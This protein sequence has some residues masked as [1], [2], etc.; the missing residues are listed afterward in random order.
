MMRA[1]AIYEGTVR[2]RRNEPKVHQF[3]FRFFM[4]LLDLEEI[5]SVFRWQ[6]FWSAK[7]W[8]LCRFK[9]TDHLKQFE[10]IG[11]LRERVLA[12]LTSHGVDQPVGPIR[13]LTQ[14][15]YLGYTMNPVSFFYCYNLNGDRIEAVIAEVNNTPWGEQHVYVIPAQQLTEKSTV[16]SEDIKKEFH[17]SPFFDLAMN[18]RM[19]FSAPKETLAVKIENHSIAPDD[20]N[21]ETDPCPRKYLEVTMKLRRKRLS[22]WNLNGLLV[23]YPAISIQVA[24]GIYWQAL[25]LYWKK[26]PFVPHPNKL[27][28]PAIDIDKASTK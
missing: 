10:S 12:A 21:T 16:R 9:A 14:L 24:A 19:A 15:S 6:P 26:I 4:L 13:L 17:V 23:R 2:H 22:G 1:S 27:N 8:S 3:D 5:D 11:N 25:R 7:R 20:A 18:Y 28:K